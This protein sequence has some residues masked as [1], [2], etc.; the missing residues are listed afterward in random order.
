MKTL[1]PEM[2]LQQEENLKAAPTV[3]PGQVKALM[4]SVYFP[5]TES[6]ATKAL[7]KH[8]GDLNYAADALMSE[9]GDTEESPAPS[10]VQSSS[11]ERDLAS[12][13]DFAPGPKKKQ[14]RRMSRASK[15]AQR[16]QRERK[17]QEIASRLDSA[18]ESLESLVNVNPNPV[19]RRHRAIVADDSDD[20][21]MS[22]PP[23]LDDGSTSPNSDYSVPTDYSSQS[24]TETTKPATKITIRLSKPSDS[25]SAS[26]GV[27]K[28][29]HSQKRPIPIQDMR[30]IKK[31]AQ[32]TAAKERRK[33]AANPNK[34][35]SSSFSTQQPTPP[36][37]T[38]GFRILHI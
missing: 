3:L 21:N 19:R 38:S 13:E 24:Q 11:V 27:N 31:Q 2:Q 1:T 34:S 35:A 20:E 32:K 17:H 12:D 29:G 15:S 18:S 25:A 6:Q 8:H 22:S 9:F 10:S 28:N 37:M 26:N 14:D 30:D 16:K 33:Q 4:S 7:E 5:I 23:A 36:V